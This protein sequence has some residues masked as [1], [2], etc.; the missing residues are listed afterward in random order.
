MAIGRAEQRGELGGGCLTGREFQFCKMKIV[1]E[2]D[3]TTV[4]M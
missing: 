4:R 1:L 2:T 3:C